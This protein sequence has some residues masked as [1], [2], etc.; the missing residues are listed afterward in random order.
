MS[1][2]VSQNKLV[3]ITYIIKDDAGDKIEQNDVPVS[4]VHGV[5]SELL[6]AL[7][8]ALDGHEVDDVVSVTI[9]PEDGFGTHDPELMFSDKID[10]VP[11]EFRYVGAQAEFQNEN[12]E[13]KLF[14]VSKIEDNMLTLDGNH[15]FAGKTVSFDATIHNIRD[16]TEEE[17]ANKTPAQPYGVDVMDT[18]TGAPH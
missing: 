6:P 7:E 17:I 9:S 1:I 15:P 2:S 13:T 4:Y 3:T 18:A 5:G 16:A 8:K 12:G 10:N 11:E 14:I